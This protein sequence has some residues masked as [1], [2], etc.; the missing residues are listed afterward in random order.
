MTFRLKIY[1]FLVCLLQTFVFQGLAAQLPTEIY[2]VASS[3][4]ITIDA[5]LDEEI[6]QTAPLQVQFLSYTPTRGD[7]L[8]FGTDVWLAFDAE[9]IYVAFRCFD[10]EPD[11]IKTSVTQR[12]KIFADDWVGF[13][14]DAQGNCQSAYDLFVNPNGIQGDILNSAV[15]GEDISPDFVWDSAGQ[16]TETGYQVEIK[17]PLRSIRFHAGENVKMGI[18]FWRQISRLGMSGSWPALE[19]GKGLFNSYATVTFATLKCPFNLEMLP[20]FTFSRHRERETLQTWN[21]PDVENDFGVGIKYGM[22]SAITAE[23]TFNPDF[24]QVESDAFQVEVNRRFPNFYPEKRPFFME[25]LEIMKFSLIEYGSMRSAVHTRQIIAPDWG[26]KLTGTVGKSA[27]GILAASDKAAGLQGD[28]PDT[29]NPHPGEAAK[30]F[31]ARSKRSMGGDNFFGTIY[32]GCEFGGDYN[33]VVGIDGQYRFFQ[34]QQTNV[35]IMQSFNRESTDAAFYSGNGLN[36]THS[37]RSKNFGITGALE[38]YDSNFKMAS[39]FLHRTGITNGWIWIGPS[40]YPKASKFDLLKRFS[41]QMVLV[42]L[43]DLSSG[44]DDSYFS[45]PIEFSFSRQGL[46]ML[47]PVLETESWEGVSYHKKLFNIFANAELKKWF[48]VTCV[49]QQGDQIYYDGEPAFLGKFL[50]VNLE[51]RWQPHKNFSQNFDWYH[52]KFYQHNTNKVEYEVNIINSRTTYQINKYLFIR[53]TL[54]YD[55]YEKHLFSNLLASFTLIP[56]TVIHLG[57]GTIH[58]KR[59]WENEKWVTKRGQHFNT[60]RGLFFKASYLWRY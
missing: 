7:S 5:L 58:E 48:G 36:L 44:L 18:I 46:I 1:H 52:E 31:I 10:T 39:A 11:R 20:S 3:H 15:S 8:P 41:P 4:S 60:E 47:E 19:A 25:G 56:G 57:Y 30:Y 2:P 34:K 35:S 23:V 9:N 40:F 33:H 55:S 26:S 43:H 32:S 12:D 29:D 38:H 28:D 53:A 51:T 13:S 17:L 16:L 50:S 21:R 45:L 14:L 49:V 24:S 37:Y 27:F 59:A 22:T 42:Y 6:W 54:R